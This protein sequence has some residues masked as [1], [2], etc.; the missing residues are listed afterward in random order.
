MA[1]TDSSTLVKSVGEQIQLAITEMKVQPGE[2]DYEKMLSDIFE[3]DSLDAA[4]DTADVVHLQ[5]IIGTPITIRGAHLAD[6]DFAGS[7]LPVF[8]IMDVTYDN[9]DEAIVT[10]GATQCVALLVKAHTAGWFPMR[11][12]TRSDTTSAGNTVIRFVKAEPKA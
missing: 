5:D 2:F 7:V 1:K 8:A 11:V 12:N 10:V 9:G 3:A 4:L 6:S